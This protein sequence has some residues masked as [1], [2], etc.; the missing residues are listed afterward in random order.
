MKTITNIIILLI[1]SINSVFSQSTFCNC[2]FSP[3]TYCD[4]R[5][6]NIKDSLCLFLHKSKNSSL[7]DVNYNK[8]KIPD[9]AAKPTNWS[10]PYIFSLP[11]YIH[12]MEDIIYGFSEGTFKKK[13]NTIICYDAVFKRY[14]T[15]NQLDEYTLVA[16][17]HTALFTK[18]DTLKLGSLFRNEDMY[19]QDMSWR[20]N[21]RDGIWK[22]YNADGD[23]IRYVVYKNDSI[24][25]RYSEKKNPPTTQYRRDTNHE[26]RPDTISAIQELQYLI[27]KSMLKL[28]VPKILKQ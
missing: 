13:D 9:K 20:G 4:R 22:S 28:K 7:F 24:I 19:F 10:E 12:P 25:N 5:F 1:F 17:K 18:G 21:K 8:R 11:M 16:T 23:S 3:S 6:Y 27:E 2:V 14:Y 26:Q 15:F